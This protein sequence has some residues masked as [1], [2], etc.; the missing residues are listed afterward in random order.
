MSDHLTIGRT[1]GRRTSRL[2]LRRAR[3]A[4]SSGRP[5]S[6]PSSNPLPH[7]VEEVDDHNEARD[8]VARVQ[9]HG[10]EVCAAWKAAR[11]RERRA[12]HEEEA[13]PLIGVDGDERCAECECRR[14]PPDQAPPITGL[15]GFEGKDGRQP[16]GQEDYRAPERR[17]TSCMLSERGQDAEPI[18]T[19][20]SVESIAPKMKIS[21]AMNIHIPSRTFVILLNGQ[22]SVTS[23]GMLNFP[24]RHPSPIPLSRRRARRT[25]VPEVATPRR[26]SSGERSRKDIP[27]AA[28]SSNGLEL[29]CSLWASPMCVGSMKRRRP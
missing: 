20:M 3:T 1:S 16:A 26:S 11:P 24:R 10:E 27:A 2:C 22:H 15:D 18:L 25:P 12:A 17:G 7:L 9:P 5:R 13:V 14:E 19:K 29:S 4:Q 28:E 8:H 6:C 23:S 21:V